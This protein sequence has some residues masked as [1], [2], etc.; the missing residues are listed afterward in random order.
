LL[1][2]ISVIT[3]SFNQGKYLEETIQSVL[4][5]D[6]PNLEY[7]VMD[8][9]S[10]DNSVAI[11]KKYEKYLTFWTSGVDD[12]M[13]DAIQNGFERSTGEIM[14]WINSDDLLSKGSLEQVADLFQKYTKIEWLCGS[15]CHI[16]EKSNIVFVN[17]PKRWN[18]FKF[19]L[20]YKFVQQE[21]TFWRRALW[22]RAGG[23][24]SREYKMASDLELWLRF[25][26][27]AD[28][29]S[30]NAPLGCF[31]CR[32]ENQKTLN[33]MQ[34][35]Y[36]EAESAIGKAPLGI[37]DRRIISK[38]KFYLRFLNKFY[39]VGNNRFIKK[40]FADPILTYPPEIIFDRV[41]Q[42]YFLNRG[43]LE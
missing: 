15:F 10:T 43:L 35:Y 39:Y 36:L 12:G 21:G 20:D 2:R 24:V 4:S 8:G 13:Y 5:Q 32:R 31:R 30:L 25:F 40:W 17:A 19:H 41:S 14:T 33:S 1:P 11:I 9:G 27:F 38:Y 16:D 37:K 28:L 29:Y 42:S 26:Q 7:I 3:P 18:R 23:Y 22:D 34:E 6:Y